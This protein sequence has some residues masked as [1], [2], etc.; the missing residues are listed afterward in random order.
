MSN[1]TTVP[2]MKLSW[3]DINSRPSANSTTSSFMGMTDKTGDIL[4]K[5][6]YIL[7]NVYG[8]AEPGEV[9]AIMGASGAGKTSLLNILTQ[10]NLQGVALSG[11]IKVNG[12]EVDANLLRRVSAYVQQT[13]LFIG[14][15]TVYEHLNFVANL[16]MG[17][18]STKDQIEKRINFLIDEL[19]LRKCAKNVIGWPHKEKGISGGERKRLAFASEVVTAPPLLFCDE[20][21]S[22]LDSF[23]ARQVIQVLKNLAAKHRMTIVVT[24]HQPSSQVFEL[25]DKIC[26]MAEGRVAYFGTIPKAIEYWSRLGKAIPKNFNPAD[27]IINTLAIK[28]KIEIK[29]QKEVK[30]ICDNFDACEAGKEL[31]DAAVGMRRGAHPSFLTFDDLVE[32]DPKLRNK[33]AHQ[34]KATYCQ[35][36]RFLIHRGLLVTIREPMLLKVRLFQ[37]IAIALILGLVYWQ[38]PINQETVMNVNGLIFQSISNLNFMFQFVIVYLFCDELPI[39]LR[40]HH[41]SLYRVDAYF[42]AKMIADIPQFVLYPVVFST[43]VYWMVGLNATAWSFFIFLLCGTLV[44]NVAISIG[45]M[46]SCIFSSVGVAV[47]IMPI[48]TIPLLAFSGFYINIANLPWYFAWLRYFSYFGYA[49]E[50]MSINEWVNHD[51]IDGCTIIPG[52]N[53][54]VP[55]NCY[56]SGQ[57]VLKIYSFDASHEYL[58]IFL[59]IVLIVAIRGIAFLAL[60]RKAR[61]TN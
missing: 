38:T 49:F 14:S 40:E 20:P 55:H 47:A 58:N 1:V 50:A 12:V 2:H 29:C 7:K 54:T 16:R 36:L 41:S 33:T 4:Q 3:H 17:R 44:T 30:Q 53:T 60:L 43:I 6:P 46:A 42:I 59:L 15:M 5:R 57:D 8:V 26:F 32:S 24:I 21:T 34:Y 56:P 9:L 23:L 22:G 19:G 18:T 52:T 45:Y 51:T 11:K 28:K 10:Q 27:H 35:Q 25:F 13:D 48:F 31:Y 39:F 37:S 61:A